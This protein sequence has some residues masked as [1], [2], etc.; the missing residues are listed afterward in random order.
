MAYLS[1][2]HRRPRIYTRLCLRCAVAR[3]PGWMPP[4]RIYHQNV[5]TPRRHSALCWPAG[6]PIFQNWNPDVAVHQDVHR[7]HTQHF[8][9]LCLLLYLVVRISARSARRSQ[10]S[11]P[12]LPL[13]P[14]PRAIVASRL[15]W[16]PAIRSATR[17]T[18][19]RQA[20]SVRGCL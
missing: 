12:R 11:C 19:A 14:E 13:S 17:R 15:P 6:S 18:P 3:S 8:P 2:F 16:S 1:S 7:G 5:S 20:H 4:P 9:P 10:A